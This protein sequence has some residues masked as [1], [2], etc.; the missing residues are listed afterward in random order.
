[1]TTQGQIQ[2]GVEYDRARG[3]LRRGEMAV[4]TDCPYCNRRSLLLFPPE[5]GL[6]MLAFCPSQNA[7]WICAACRRG[8]TYYQISEDAGKTEYGYALDQNRYGRITAALRIAKRAN[9]FKSGDTE[10][11]ATP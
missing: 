8:G 5:D 6:Q 11:G 3:G 4:K 9:L 2:A 1:M 10:S 7:P